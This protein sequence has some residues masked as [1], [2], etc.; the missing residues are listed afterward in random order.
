MKSKTGQRGLLG[1]RTILP[2]FKEKRTDKTGTTEN[3]QRKLVSIL[4]PKET[5]KTGM[6]ENNT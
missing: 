2:R 3:N 6:T 5:N 4:S 1:R